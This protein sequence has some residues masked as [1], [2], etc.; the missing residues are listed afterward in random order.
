MRVLSL[1]LLLFLAVGVGGTAVA[2][3]S[4]LD[5]RCERPAEVGKASSLVAVV[6]AEE[7]G[8]PPLAQFPTPLITNDTELSIVRQGEGAKAQIGSSVDFQVAAYLGSTGQFLTASSFVPDDTIRR[9]IN[10]ESEDYFERSL[11]CAQAGDRLVITDTVEQVFGPIPEDELVQND[12]TVVVIV[13][14]VQSYLR[15]AD[16]YWNFYREDIPLVV[17]HPD[18]PHGIVMPSVAP[19]TE[20]VTHAVKKGQGAPLAEGDTAVV[21]FTAVVWETQQAFASSFGQGTPINVDL[22]APDE[23]APSAVLPGIYDGL[24]GQTV[25][26]QVAIVVPP[27]EGYGDGQLPQGVPAGATLVYVFDIVGSF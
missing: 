13:D 15:E 3:G 16:G 20:T 21:T 14:V 26:S 8:Q 18:G 5:P 25:G 2:V 27:G 4:S 23:S 9:V 10:P 7:E 11:V 6:D 17:S 12:S 19:P 1:F 24:I 22:G